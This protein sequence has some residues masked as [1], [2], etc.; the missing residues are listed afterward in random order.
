MPIT[1]RTHQ[2]RVHCAVLG[3]PVVGDGKYGGADAFL[4][5][6]VSRKMHLH[7]REIAVPH[8]AGG[9]LHVRAPLPDHM[10]ASWG[11]FEFDPDDT[12]DHFAELEI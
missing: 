11:L 12:E 3:T 2:L 6:S 4:S 9:M 10:L 1:G 5:G 7:A 8:P